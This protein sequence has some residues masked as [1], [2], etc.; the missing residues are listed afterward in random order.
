MTNDQLTTCPNCGCDGCYKTPLNETMYNYFCWGC[1]FQTNDLIKK[2]SFD[3]EAYEE[4]LPELYKDAKSEDKEGRVWYP[5]TINLENKGTVFL[6][7]KSVETAE[8]SGIKV[9]ELTSEEKEQPKFKNKTHKSDAKS[10]RSFGKDFIEACDYVGFFE[11][12]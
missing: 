4:I 5:I 6:N 7:G 11:E 1:G 10:L 3:F 8:W 2:G 9:I 12:N